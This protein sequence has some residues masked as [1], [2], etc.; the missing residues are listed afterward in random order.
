MNDDA[1]D[2]EPHMKTKPDVECMKIINIY[3]R[4]SKRDLHTQKKRQ[5]LGGCWYMNESVVLCLTVP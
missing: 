2:D 1:S 4:S 5:K 3:F